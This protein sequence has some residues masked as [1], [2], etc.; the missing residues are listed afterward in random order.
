MTSQST[1]QEETESQ[2]ASKLATIPELVT[3]NQK[4]VVCARGFRG[5]KIE[6]EAR[7][8]NIAHAILAQ[9]GKGTSNLGED[10]VICKKK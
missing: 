8:T 4:A 7:E 2:T 6:F 9:K 5:K 3:D 10:F 1:T